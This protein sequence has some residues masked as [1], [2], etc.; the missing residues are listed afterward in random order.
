[1]WRSRTASQP[2]RS[3][4]RARTTRCLVLCVVSALRNAWRYPKLDWL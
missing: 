3:R 2:P 4:G 1:V